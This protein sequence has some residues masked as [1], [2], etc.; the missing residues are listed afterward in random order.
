MQTDKP[1]INE[2]YVTWVY[3][4]INVNRSHTGESSCNMCAVYQVPPNCVKRIDR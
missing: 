1:R 4:Q 3:K 2:V